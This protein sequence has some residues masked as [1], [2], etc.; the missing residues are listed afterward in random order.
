[1]LEWFKKAMGIT[2]KREQAVE[3]PKQPTDGT[4]TNPVVIKAEPKK[5]ATRK[6][7]TTKKTTAKKSTKKTS[8]KKAK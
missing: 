5:K 8:A 1:M 6:K 4:L 7:A 2:P 3:E